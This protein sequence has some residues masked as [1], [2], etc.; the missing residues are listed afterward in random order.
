MKIII[1]NRIYLYH[2]KNPLIRKS[3]IDHLTIVNPMHTEAVKAGRRHFHIPKTLSMFNQH[4]ESCFSIPRGAEQYLNF[5]LDKYDPSAEFEDQTYLSDPEINFDCNITV[6][7]QQIPAIEAGL[8]TEVNVISLPTGAGKTVCALYMV[9]KRKQ[10]TFILVHT[11]ELLYQWQARIKQ[12][13]DYD[14]GLVGDNK[15]KIKDITVGIKQSVVNRSKSD[16]FAK[17][18]GYLILD[19]CH[20]V[21][22]STFTEAVDLFESYY[23]TGLTATPKRRDK[24]EKFIFFA[25][26]DLSYKLDKKHSIASGKILKPTIIKRNTNLKF[27][28]DEESTYVELLSKLKNSETRNQMI[29]E[30]VLKQV[31]QNYSCCLVLSDHSTHLKKI[32]NIFDFLNIK[33]F[34]LT[35]SI[36]S[37]KRKI[38]VKELLKGNIRILLATNS[39]IGEGFDYSGFTD[40]F[41]TTPIGSNERLEQ[42]LGRGIRTEQGKTNVNIFDYVDLDSVFQGQWN[43]RRKFYDTY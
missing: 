12:F 43:R 14:C 28:G 39:L 38:T 17:K 18:F 21:P 6:Y 26:G 34:V 25:L 27:G 40:M 24:M 9:H 35:G 31:K 11:K 23:I 13:L 41:F 16:N 37:S 8:S 29:V 30:D 15:F 33:Y 32:Q 4:T 2:C 5:L 22:S 3:L 20:K 42:I 1:S 7:K 19:E 36:S 10:S